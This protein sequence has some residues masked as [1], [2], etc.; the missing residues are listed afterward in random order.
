M[1]RQIRR[2]TCIQ[3]SGIFSADLSGMYTRFPKKHCLRLK[4]SRILFEK[5]G[6]FHMK[7]RKK[8]SMTLHQTRLYSINEYTIPG[9]EKTVNCR[10]DASLRPPARQ[11]RSGEVQGKNRG[12]SPNTPGKRPK[13]AFCL[14]GLPKERQR[15]S[16]SQWK[17]NDV[18]RRPCTA[19][20]LPL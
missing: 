11:Q 6:A 17:P 13:P 1:E 20:A 12:N 8:R 14:S 19:P 3:V 7:R 10:T 2:R 5:S 16:P 18:W 15:S 9:F 4:N